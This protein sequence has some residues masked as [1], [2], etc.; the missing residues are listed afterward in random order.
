MS[1]PRLWFAGT[2]PFA[3]HSLALLLDHDDYRIDAV[4]T[5]PDRPAG[6]G[7]K[8]KDSAV[9]KIALD[10]GLALDQPEKLR[11]NAAP[12]ADL[13]RPDL[14]IV[15]AYGLLL[16][17]W[18]L[19]SPRFGCI[20][21]HASLLPRWR[22]AAPIQRAIAA[23]D[24]ETGISIMQMDAGLDTGPI[25][26]EKRLTITAED[27]AAT[28]T[29]KL[30]VLGGEALLEALPRILRGEGKATPQAENGAVYAPKLG[31]A[32]ARIDWSR[33]AEEIARNIRAYHPKPVAYSALEGETI[34]IHGAHACLPKATATPGEIIRHDRSGLLVGAGQGAVLITRLQLSGKKTIT[35]A[36]LANSRNL[37]GKH[38]S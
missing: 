18:F 6:R 17:D 37:Q 29:E 11:E 30:T 27:D 8:Q 3:A 15:A 16:P 33:A 36:S 23:G 4:L 10:A 21:I 9:K 2:P 25:W 13:P 20:N 7:R 5:R 28:L 32:E 1:R 19:T 34:R 14:C 24:R 22:G 38:F 35:A 12:F 31:K 26:L